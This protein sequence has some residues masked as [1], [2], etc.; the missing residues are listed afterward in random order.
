MQSLENSALRLIMF[1]QYKIMGLLNKSTEDSYSYYQ[2]I[3]VEGI[4]TKYPMLLETIGVGGSGVPVKVSDDV[5]LILEI[6]HKVQNSIARLDFEVQK[7]LKEGYHIY[8]DGFSTSNETE[9]PYYT[10]NKFVHKYNEV[11]LPIAGDGSSGL[12]LH[13]YNRMMNSYME[14]RPYEILSEEQ[15]RKICIRKGEEAGAYEAILVDFTDSGTFP[16]LQLIKE[17]I[18]YKIDK[19]PAGKE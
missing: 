14:Y 3:I 1:N 12:T 15:I 4:E 6:F 17:D 11:K 19:K 16:P 7:E 13:H 5:D 18:A 9:R 2:D 8:F 10:Y